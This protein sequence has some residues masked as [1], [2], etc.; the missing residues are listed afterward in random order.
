MNFFIK[1]IICCLL[2]VTFAHSPALMRLESPP[3]TVPSMN[4][5]PTLPSGGVAL[6]IRDWDHATFEEAANEIFNFQGRVA[7]RALEQEYNRLHGLQFQNFIDCIVEA[8]QLVVSGRGHNPPH[9]ALARVVVMNSADTNIVA[10]PIPYVFFSKEQ[11]QICL[12]S[13]FRNRVDIQH[14]PDDIAVEKRELFK[15]ISSYGFTSEAGR[16]QHFAHSERAVGLCLN[17]T[18]DNF[19][20]SNIVN[21]YNISHD[22]QFVAGGGI[23]PNAAARIIIQIKT[24]LPICEFC[25]DFWNDHAGFE[26]MVFI[27][28]DDEADDDDDDDVVIVRRY[29]LR[30]SLSSINQ[31]RSQN[32]RLHLRTTTE[33]RG[34]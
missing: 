27:G 33:I 31:L 7:G 12:G 20:L 24:A 18:T 5:A 25:Q 11:V 4:D 32:A 30:H 17:S 23:V 8:K 10:Y 6:S 26:G 3:V 29:P 13:W 21:D 9:V 15:S 22:V 19:R 2:F 34:W 28:V 16:E 14:L 1:K